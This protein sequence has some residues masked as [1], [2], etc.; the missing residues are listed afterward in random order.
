[1]NILSLFDGMS[2]LQIALR[3]AD[4]SIDKYYASE[5]DKYAI[6]QTSFAFPNTVQ[7]GDVTKWREWD[8]DWAKIDLIGAGSPCQG[9]SLAGRQKAFDDPRSKL[10]WIFVKILNHV[11]KLN[12][13]VKFLLENVVMKRKH[14]QVISGALGIQPVLIDSARVSAQHRERY[15]WSNIRT[16]Y[17]GL[18]TYIPQPE[19]RNIVIADILDEDVPDKYY[20]SEARIEKIFKH[21]E[22]QKANRT[23]F[24][25]RIPGGEDKA[26]TVKCS[27]SWQ[28]ELIYQIPRGYNDGGVHVKAPT[29]TSSA[30]IQNNFIIQLND[31]HEFGTQPRQ[32]NRVYSA[33]G[34]SPSC[35][36]MGGGGRVTNIKDWA[37]K[38]RR[39]TPWEYAK[40][41]TVPEW[42]KWSPEISN[43][44]IYNLCGNG[45][46]VAVIV[47]ILKQWR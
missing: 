11:R 12:P 8:I 45:W 37:G 23:G 43:T 30:Y 6:K 13:D 35:M 1:M 41:Q 7:L 9:F 44:Q 47:H 20:L 17:G 28:D 39:L 27:G 16:K 14:L 2:C 22:R 33:V 31:A 15:Y 26:N 21:A 10:F 5:I 32:Q 36:T 40:L 46:T 19:D 38:I 18:Q 25:A 42:Y 29:L 34:K 24:S 4:I 3:E